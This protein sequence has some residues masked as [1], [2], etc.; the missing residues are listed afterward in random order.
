MSEIED[1]VRR[2]VI[3]FQKKELEE[4]SGAFLPPVDP[5][6]DDEVQDEWTGDLDEFERQMEEGRQMTVREYVGWPSVRPLAEVPLDQLED[7]LDRILE[8][9]YVNSVVVDFLYDIELAEAYRFVTEELL[10]EIVTEIRI[11]EMFT[12][13]IY[14]DFYPNDIEDIKD[15]GEEF[16]TGFLGE[17]DGPLWVHL[18]SEGLLDQSGELLVLD[19]IIQLMHNFHIIHDPVTPFDVELLSATVEEDEG[20]TLFHVTWYRTDRQTTELVKLSASVAIH[21]RRSPY[22]GWDIVQAT[23]PFD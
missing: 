5:C 19:R 18:V 23:L 14:E 12:H 1:Q 9:L 3:E 2:I 10:D 4:D 6:L 8:I 20:T 13:F 17:Q 21:F 11:P 22:G 16:L 7:E 15:A